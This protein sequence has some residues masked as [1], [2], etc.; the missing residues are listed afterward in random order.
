MLGWRHGLELWGDMAI[1]G[2]RR[3]LI[4]TFGGAVIAYPFG[5][6]AQ[7]PGRIRQIGVL[8]ALSADDPEARPRVAAFEQ[9][10]QQLGWLDPNRLRIEYRWA[11]GAQ[12]RIKSYAAELVTMGSDV[13]VAN[14]TP[15][16]AAVRQQTTSI[17]IV[18]VQVTDP[19]NTGF[20]KS[21]AQPGGNVTG[22]TNFE[23]PMGGK[24]VS[25]LKAIAPATTSVAVI[26][27]PKTAPYGGSFFQEIK[28]SAASLDIEAIDAQ[29]NDINDLQN[30][31]VAIA[32]KPHG[33]L[34]I[35]PDTFAA[36][37]RKSI[38]ALAAQYKLPAIYPFRYYAN[39]GGL[40]S[41]GIDVVDSFRR[42]ASYVDRIL[43][44]ESPGNLPV[45]APTKYELVINL[46]TANALGLTVPAMLRVLADDVIE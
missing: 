20:I 12:D 44:G 4:K 42:S 6:R 43:K 14:T 30:A 37:N 18:F 23:F 13:I 7:Q 31:V 16:L 17:P 1:D 26:F 2:T 45:E 22:F 27:N 46:K 36:V 35:V 40:I 15:I 25:T 29:S 11:G 33:S 5:A 8:M 3:R 41:Y 19:V 21:L 34:I 9:G 10:L 38:V 39:D 28:A 32:Q 24:W